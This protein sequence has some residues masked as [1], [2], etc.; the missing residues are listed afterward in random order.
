MP[1]SLR[2]FDAMALVSHWSA[3]A[4]LLPARSATLTRG[5]RRGGARRPGDRRV[6]PASVALST[7]RR[8]QALT[9]PTTLHSS[10][11]TCQN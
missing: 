2:D 6:A 9:A 10:W 8:L 11:S 3:F 4:K 5:R 1:L 7:R